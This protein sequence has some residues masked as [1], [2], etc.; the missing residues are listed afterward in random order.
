MA[1]D[2][3]QEA[4]S[5]DLQYGRRGPRVKVVSSAFQVRDASDTAFI[6]LAGA[7][8]VA[9]DDFVTKRQ[10]AFSGDPGVIYSGLRGYT[11]PS[12]RNSYPGSGTAVTDML[13]GGTGGV[14]S[15]GTIYLNG[16]FE[17]DGASG[18][19]TFTKTSALD[20]IFGAGGSGVGG[21]ALAFVDPD[22]DGENNEGRIADT[23]DGIAEGWSFYTRGET[24]AVVGLGFQRAFDTTTGVWTTGTSDPVNEGRTSLVGLTYDDTDVANVP[25]FYVADETY[26]TTTSTAPVGTAVSDVGNPL[27]IGNRTGD[28]R[29]FNG[30][31]GPVMLFDRI[32]DVDEIRQVANIFAARFLESALGAGTIITRSRTAGDT[33]NIR[34]NQVINPPTIDSTCVGCINLQ[35]ETSASHGVLANVDN[36]GILTGRNNI[37]GGDFGVVCGGRDND[38]LGGIDNF[39]GGGFNNEITS[40]TSKSV[41]VGGTGHIIA[42]PSG[43][44]DFSGIL[45]G[46]RGKIFGS[47]NGVICGGEDCTLGS[48]ATSNNTNHAGIVA[49]DTSRIRGSRSFIGAGFFNNIGEAAGLTVTD[50]VIPGGRSNVVNATGGYAMGR[51]SRV[52]ATHVGAWVTSDST[53]QNDDSE[54]ANEHFLRYAGG[55]RRRATPGNSEESWIN[56]NDHLSLTGSSTTGTV[57]LGTLSTNTRTLDVSNLRL[58]GIRTDSAAGVADTFA[59][60]G[61]FTGRRRND[62]NQAI[63]VQSLTPG[64]EGTGVNVTA[65]L[66]ITG[67]DYEILVTLPAAVETWEFTLRWQR[68]VG[69]QP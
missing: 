52:L 31:M 49:G 26:A 33:E 25:T 61:G 16:F 51:Q 67:N 63:F 68:Q 23:S 45:S 17:F 38:M 46:E 7:D 29:T 40:G 69:G 9:D 50:A 58:H 36:S 47:S 43:S 57:V 12:D 21:T 10:A 14:L 42:P 55:L 30:G 41:I 53:I 65:V 59:S 56:D 8:A 3:C 54:V 39:F 20:N 35:E 5:D 15:G 24:G 18:A 48:S 1:N 64:S 28:D 60:E 6:R 22:N 37:M 32:L 11:D 19:L 62:G 66:Q 44:A 27:V 4:V 13:G 34:G 2:F